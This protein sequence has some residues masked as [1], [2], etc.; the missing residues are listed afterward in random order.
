MR[1]S[2]VLKPL[3]WLV[4]TA[5]LAQSWLIPLAKASASAKLDG[6]VICTAGGF[7][8]ISLP[9]DLRPPFDPAEESDEHD[10]RSLDCTAC[11]VQAVGQALSDSQRRVTSV[12]WPDYPFDTVSSILSPPSRWL[13][14]HPTRAPPIA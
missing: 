9:D 12:V 14:A 5:L 1:R 8:V 10:Q 4:S 13:R 3:V 7:K 2:A 11:L 6:I